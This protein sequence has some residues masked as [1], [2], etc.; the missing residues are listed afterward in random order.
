MDSNLRVT[1][2][3]SYPIRTNDAG[4]NGDNHRLYDGRLMRKERGNDPLTPL[5]HKRPYLVCSNR[6][7]ERLQRNLP[8]ICR[9]GELIETEAAQRFV[10]SS[11]SST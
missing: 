5:Y 1:R 9:C 2:S 3:H 8:S 4:R 11:P 6:L 10:P 7:Y